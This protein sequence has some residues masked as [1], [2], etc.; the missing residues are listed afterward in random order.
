M[1]KSENDENQGPLMKNYRRTGKIT[2]KEPVRVVGLR[3]VGKRIRI[4]RML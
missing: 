1:T 2:H 4:I 3:R